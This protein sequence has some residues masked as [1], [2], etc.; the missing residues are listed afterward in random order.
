MSEANKSYRIKYDQEKQTDHLNI[1]IDHDFDFL[2]VL[3]MKISQE[4]AYRLYT[5]NYGVIVGR[6]LANDGFGIPN[7][8]VSIFLPNNSTDTSLDSSILY[9][10]KTT[11]DK[12][13]K[14]IRYNLLPSNKINAC[15][16]NVGSLP[17]KR[18]ILDNKQKLDV[19]DSFYR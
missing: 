13:N 10:Y 14:G 11:S 4:D 9:P 2:E 16:Q 6:V 18:D 8:K 12:D 1:K 17:S 19:F 15:Y 7:A 3:S 5:S